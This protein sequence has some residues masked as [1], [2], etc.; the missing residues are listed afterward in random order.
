MRG[1]KESAANRR[2]NGERP[3]T[4]RHG[5]DVRAPVLACMENKGRSGSPRSCSLAAA[6]K[7]VANQSLLCY[8]APP[9]R[10]LPVFGQSRYRTSGRSPPK[11]DHTLPPAIPPRGRSRKGGSYE[12]SISYTSHGLAEHPQRKM[13][14]PR[15]IS[16]TRSSVRGLFK[17]SRTLNSSSFSNFWKN[18]SF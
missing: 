11:W 2:R 7:P 3:P 16:R 4:K 9:S 8:C 15:W 5:F 12:R 14:A 17:I 6:K 1:S 18:C 13:V 10:R